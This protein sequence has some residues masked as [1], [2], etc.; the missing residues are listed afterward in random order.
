MSLI[1]P[2]SQN[3]DPKSQIWR[4]WVEKS[5]QAIGSRLEDKFSSDVANTFKALSGTV[6]KLALQV[7]ELFDVTS[8]LGG[9]FTYNRDIPSTGIGWSS[10]TTFNLPGSIV[11]T[12]TEARQ[13]TVTGY[14]EVTLG[15]SHTGSGGGGSGATAVFYNSLGP[16]AISLSGTATTSHISGAT[17]SV[18][19][20]TV[21]FAQRTFTLQPGLYTVL[22]QLQV[23]ANGGSA[24]S[25]GA[26]GM[27]VQVL[28]KV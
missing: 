19:N 3:L 4:R 18:S 25:S 26:G 8:D 12:L 2:P 13:V 9:F 24:G 7:A 10:A 22:G 5:I 14:V 21:I 27:T 17:S 6:G 23:S 20:T 16:S 28:N 11:F 1:P 15:A